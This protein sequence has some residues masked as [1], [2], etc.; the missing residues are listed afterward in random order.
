MERG[1]L[2][3]ESW[4]EGGGSDEDEGWGSVGPLVEEGGKSVGP[5]EE[6]V[7]ILGER[8]L[9][10]DVAPARGSAWIISD[11]EGLN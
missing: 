11:G 10:T 4:V 8:P 9:K 6:S 2:K 1:V 3:E 7:G 5:M